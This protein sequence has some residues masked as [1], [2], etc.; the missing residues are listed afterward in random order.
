M[1]H[2]MCAEKFLNIH[3]IQWNNLFCEK[4]NRC[5]CT[6]IYSIP[7]HWQAK[8][9]VRGSYRA[10]AMPKNWGSKK[11]PPSVGWSV[12]YITYKNQ[13]NS[14]RHTHLQWIGK[15]GMEC[16]TK[17]S[18]IYRKSSCTGWGKTYKINVFVCQ[19][20]IESNSA[21]SDKNKNHSQHWL[22]KRTEPE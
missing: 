14:H 20:T 21:N 22:K 5:K 4:S 8:E 3:I 12:R 13:N 17:I 15:C 2:L 7:L 16:D 10:A 6:S 18:T 1:G 9:Y 19:Q 11:N